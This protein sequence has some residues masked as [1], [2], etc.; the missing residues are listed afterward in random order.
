MKSLVISSCLLG[1]S[2]AKVILQDSDY[3]KDSFADDY[4]ANDEDY[5]EVVE[6]F[7]IPVHKPIF[8]SSGGHFVVGHKDS[9]VLSCQVDHLGAHQMMWLKQ[10][11]LKGAEDTL[12]VG[13]V[14]VTKSPRRSL[15]QIQNNKGSILT[16]SQASVEDEGTYICKVADPSNNPD[17]MLEFSVSVGDFPTG[18]AL[19]DGKG[20]GVVNSAS[21]I[22]ILSLVLARFLL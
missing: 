21:I 19:K 20:S 11:G 4:Y 5:T 14:E 16:I 15:A 17:L 7:N 8:Q 2:L 18:V 13:T 22:S 3:Q 1:I 6:K 10:P 12:Y 9:I